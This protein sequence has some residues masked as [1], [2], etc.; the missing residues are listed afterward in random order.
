[1]NCRCPRYGGLIRTH[2]KSVGLINFV[3]DPPL[4]NVLNKG[5]ET[6]GTSDCTFSVRSRL[7]ITWT[8]DC[9]RSS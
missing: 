7:G 5:D 3:V 8:R 6:G 1:M 2:S 9:D 4:E